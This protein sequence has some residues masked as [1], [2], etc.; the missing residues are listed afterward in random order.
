MEP[1]S[2]ALL[3]ALAGGAG[4]EAGRQAWST[5]T[6][7]VRRPFRSVG[8]ADEE[9]PGSSSGLPE[10]QA[11]ER[12]PEDTDRIS[13]LNTVLAV[14][15]ALDP[16]FRAGLQEWQQQAKATV[17]GSSEVHNHISGGTQHGPVI[18]GQNFSGITFTNQPPHEPPSRT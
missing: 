17:Q 3:A 15:A 9:A 16:E 7:L 1:I 13:A 6:A 12:A 5:L 14:R 11:A 4:G 8:A 10:L 18:Q 2:L